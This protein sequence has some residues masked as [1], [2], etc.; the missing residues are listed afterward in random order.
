MKVLI[1][2][3]ELCG[4]ITAGEC[5]DG[6]TA[7]DAGL[8]VL[9]AIEGGRTLAV[10]D[11]PVSVGP[12]RCGESLTLSFDNWRRARACVELIEGY[13]FFTQRQDGYAA[14]QKL[15]ELIP[16]ATLNR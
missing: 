4:Q 10:V 14:L 16:P 13:G 11:E 12:C 1:A 3:C 5:I 9:S 6:M 7:E 15:K 2:K 8:L